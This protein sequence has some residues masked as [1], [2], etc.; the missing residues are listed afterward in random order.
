MP[1]GLL[2]F[3]GCQFWGITNSLPHLPPFSLR[4]GSPSGWSWLAQELRL[5]SCWPLHL[6]LVSRYSQ[7]RPS[8]RWQ[9][10]FHP[11]P[12]Q[13]FRKLPWTLEFV[14]DWT[15]WKCWNQTS[16]PSLILFQAKTGIFIG[17]VFERSEDLKIKLFY[18]TDFS[19]LCLIF[20]CVVWVQES[21]YSEW[22]YWGINR[23]PQY[24]LF[25]YFS[26]LSKEFIKASSHPVK[27]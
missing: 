24:Y 11:C 1:G 7:R 4:T 26:A 5:P 15:R 19:P 2:I 23:F 9:W 18:K 13:W 8:S 16:W 6:R 10:W 20:I 3:E 25:L 27:K 17:F 14:F 12:R 22:S 21:R